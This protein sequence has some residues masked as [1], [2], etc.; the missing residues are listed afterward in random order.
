MKHPWSNFKKIDFGLFG[1]KW[2]QGDRL[3]LLMYDASLHQFGMLKQSYIDS[4]LKA[5]P[6]GITIIQSRPEFMASKVI[7]ECTATILV[8]ASKVVSSYQYQGT[9][10]NRYQRRHYVLVIGYDFQQFEKAGYHTIDHQADFRLA[11]AEP[12]GRVI[13]EVLS[14]RFPQ[15]RRQINA[16]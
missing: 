3:V 11:M 2:N 13:E 15:L 12:N 4:V 8:K 5:S 1:R 7:K 9:I 16:A 14:V 10:H 6:A